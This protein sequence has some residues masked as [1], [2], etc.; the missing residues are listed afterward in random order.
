[1]DLLHQRV[2][3]PRFGTGEITGQSRRQLSVSFSSA[4]ALRRF[5]YPAAFFGHLVLCDDAA[6]AQLEEELAR[7]GEAKELLRR[8][9]TARSV[10]QA[11]QQRRRLLFQRPQRRP[12]PLRRSPERSQPLQAQEKHRA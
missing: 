1:M 6:Q 12:R 9:E 4:P 2:A 10:R 3:H 5:L 7:S 11:E 8:Q